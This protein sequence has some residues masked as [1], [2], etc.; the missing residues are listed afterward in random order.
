MNIGFDRDL[1]LFLALEEPQTP[2]LSPFLNSLVSPRS[3]LYLE[4]LVMEMLDRLL[5]SEI[6]WFN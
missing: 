4:E 5:L 3:K 1:V 6:H 2:P